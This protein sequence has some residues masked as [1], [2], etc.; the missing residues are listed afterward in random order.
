[1][2]WIRVFGVGK[3]VEA[4]GTYGGVDGPTPSPN[5]L[6]IVQLVNVHDGGVVLQPARHP[7]G[8]D[9]ESGGVGDDRLLEADLGPV[10]KGRN[11]RRVLPPSLSPALL[12]GRVAIGVLQALDVSDNARDET[13]TLHPSDQVHLQAR[14]IAFASG[15]D[16]FVLARIHLE[17]R[18]DRGIDLGIH[19][20]DRFAVFESLE[21]YV[22]TELDRARDIDD[23][24]DLA[25]AAH[26]EGVLGHGGLALAN[27]LVELGL[28]PRH[29]DIVE[30]GV[31]IDV[32]N[33][34]RAPILNS[35]HP[36]S[37]NP[38]SDLSPQPCPHEPGAPHP[39]PNRLPLLPSSS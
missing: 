3:Y 38:P 20:Y 37:P 28:R 6:K 29:D 8:S 16:D 1:M 11:H 10:C 18:A 24:I 22:S 2:F 23:H 17:N 15:K 27:G 26:H 5:R 31:A 21:N 4:S 39:L 35:P 14:F 9:L 33:A 30:P 32:L 36:P 25:R 12:G 13:Q 19:Q 7:A 34:L